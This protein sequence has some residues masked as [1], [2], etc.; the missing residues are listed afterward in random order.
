MENNGEQAKDEYEKQRASSSSLQV[1]L[2]RCSTLIMRHFLFA[3]L[4]LI[5]ASYHQ[6]VHC[7]VQPTP[8]LSSWNTPISV[9]AAAAAQPTDGPQLSEDGKRVIAKRDNQIQATLSLYQ[10]WASVCNNDNDNQDYQ[11]N[12]D[13]DASIRKLWQ[14]VTE[15]VYCG[16]GR[17]MTVTRTITATAIATATV[18][19]GSDG[20]VECDAQCWSDYLWRKLPSSFLAE[21][22][23]LSLTCHTA[24]TR[25]IWL[26]DLCSSGFYWYRLHLDWHRLYAFWLPV[27]SANVGPGR[28]CLFRYV[29][30]AVKLFCHASRDLTELIHS[31]SYHD[32]DWSCQ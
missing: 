24:T 9:V 27:L 3:I 22:L 10:D 32:M 29:L 23:L 13:A 11:V 4:F 1:F 15:T 17:V 26:W 6:G 28:L 12:T 16:N 21:L 5:F 7:L 8:S 19:S 2:F 30:Y 25:H 14:T 31:G 20:Q 18:Y